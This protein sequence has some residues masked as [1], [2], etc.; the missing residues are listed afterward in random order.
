VRIFRSRDAAINYLKKKQ[1]ETGKKH[2]LFAVQTKKKLREKED[3]A[4][5]Y[6][7]QKEGETVRGW[8]EGWTD[9]EEIDYRQIDLSEDYNFLTQLRG[10]FWEWMN[11]QGGT[12]KYDVN[13]P[14]IEGWTTVYGVYEGQPMYD[15]DPR[16]GFG[17]GY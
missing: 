6:R 12:V 3:F 5:D 17:P 8:K 1:K 11:R 14:D 10:G 2:S 4:R 9:P 7:F 16:P 15:D 13:P